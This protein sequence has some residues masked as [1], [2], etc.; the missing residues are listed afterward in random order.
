MIPTNDE[1]FMKS[2]FFS[3]EKEN[4]EYSLLIGVVFLVLWLL[5]LFYRRRKDK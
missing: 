5:L 4:A 3:Y 1:F 2:K